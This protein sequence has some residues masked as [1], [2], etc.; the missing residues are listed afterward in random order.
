MVKKIRKQFG[1]L[2]EGINDIK[3]DDTNIK[4]LIADI[5]TPAFGYEKKCIVAKNTG[6]FKKEGK[7]KSSEN[8]ETSN[9]IAEY[10]KENEEIVKQVVVLIFIE[11]E[12]DKNNLYKIIEQKG[13]ICYFDEL[14]PMQIIARLKSICSSYKVQVEDFSLKYLIE[15]V[16]TNMQDLINE[17]RKLIEYVGETGKIEKKDI[18][19]LCIKQFETIIF[20]LTDNLGKRNI[21]QAINILHQLLE[22]KEPIQ[23]I[24]INLY[25]HFKKLYI[26]KLADK[27]NKPLIECLGLKQNQTFLI[28]KY[29]TQANYFKE[30][31]LKNI[32][33]RLI[34]LDTCSKRGEIDIEVGLETILCC[35]C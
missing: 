4:E 31:E 32:L 19:I 23:K 33:Q 27:R 30:Q 34:E 12:V 15:C 14:K 29:K 11:Q 13:T 21:K 1:E 18:D 17:I 25:N 8:L 26:T 9:R 5:E 28:T 2:K 24:L 16:G 20:D 3:L 35:Y 22:D 6:L 10:M 7:R